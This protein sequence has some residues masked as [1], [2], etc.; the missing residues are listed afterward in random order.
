MFDGRKRVGFL[1]SSVDSFVA[2]NGE[3]VRRGARFSQ[4]SATEREE[5]VERARRLARAGGCPAEVT[6]RVAE[7]MGR[8]VETIRYTL[9]Q[10]DREHPDL[11]VFP[12]STGPLSDDA[13]K[14]IYQQYRRGAPVEALAK[15]YCRTKTSIYRV[16]NEMRAAADLPSC[17][18]TYIPNPQ[19]A[20]AGAEKEILGPLPQPND[21]G[22]E[23]PAAQRLASLP[24]Q[25]VRGAAADAR[26]G[27]PSVPQVQLPEVP[28]GQAARGA[29]SGC[30]PRAA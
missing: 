1:K 11:A 8:S 12:E 3:R 30:G 18:W 5:I 26:A 4:L 13:K 10:F 27:S 19:F 9:K 7:K 16:I 23:D 14:K 22:Q 2:R 24:G 6:R 20:K 28:G 29:R 17:R 25:P 21:A 15:Q